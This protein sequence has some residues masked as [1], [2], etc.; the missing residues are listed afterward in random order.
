M[1]NFKKEINKKNVD[2]S[3]PESFQPSP[4]QKDQLAMELGGLEFQLL[5]VHQSLCQI[6]SLHCDESHHPRHILVLQLISSH[7]PVHQSAELMEKNI[8]H[9]KK[10]KPRWILNGSDTVP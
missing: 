8:R 5:I 1:Q 7:I 3:R 6:F 4:C 9:K 10:N 2:V